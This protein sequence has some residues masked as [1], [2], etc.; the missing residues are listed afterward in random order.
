M[1]T[2]KN[3]PTALSLETR[4]GRRR[5]ITSVTTLED[6]SRIFAIERDRSGMASSRSQDGIVRDQ[7]GTVIAIVTYNAR[8]WGPRGWQPGTKPLVEAQA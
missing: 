1:A 4:F 2:S 7:A 5:A 3:E 8:V 6:A